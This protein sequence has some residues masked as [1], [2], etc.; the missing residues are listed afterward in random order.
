ML[1]EVEVQK[2]WCIEELIQC[3]TV[4]GWYKKIHF[5]YSHFDLHLAL[6]GYQ[7]VTPSP[8]GPTCGLPGEAGKTTITV[9]DSWADPSTVP[10]DFGCHL[11]K[12]DV[13]SQILPAIVASRCSG[14]ADPEVCAC[15]A[16]ESQCSSLPSGI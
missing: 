14:R 11:V 5:N 7:F 9:V 2:K 16:Q 15:L 13:F 1:Q 8:S 12:E 6:S 10:S 4:Q 3:W